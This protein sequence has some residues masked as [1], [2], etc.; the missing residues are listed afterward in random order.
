MFSLFATHLQEHLDQALSRRRS[1]NGGSHPA[2]PLAK[3]RKGSKPE[4]A[5]P[6]FAPLI[7]TPFS[8]PMESEGSI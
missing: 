5:K 2:Q 8:L 7:L 4:D 1:Q 3:R 6:I